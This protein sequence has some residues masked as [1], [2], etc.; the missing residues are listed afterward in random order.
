M[1]FWSWP[2]GPPFMIV[3]DCSHFFQAK[4]PYYAFNRGWILMIRNT[5]L[6]KRV[7]EGLL[8]FGL[9]KFPEIFM[10]QGLYSRDSLLRV[11]N[12]QR[13]YE[14]QTIFRYARHQTVYSSSMLG[15]KVDFHMSS[16]PERWKFNLLSESIQNLVS[17]RAQNIMNLMHLI[18]LIVAGKDGK[19]GYDFK[20]HASHT[21]HIHLEIIISIREETLWSSVPT[22]WNVSRIKN[23][24]YSVYGCLEYTPLQEPKSANFTKSP[25]SKIFSLHYKQFRYGLTSRWK[26][27]FRCMYSIDFNSWYI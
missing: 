18:Q 25:V 14:I 16:L 8:C 2:L 20:H 19:Q 6:L 3:P 11:I 13:F 27:P 15:R 26:I 24:K 4:H 22:C 17:G 23:F 5:H 7:R 10:L 21:P 12:K 1:S 9:I